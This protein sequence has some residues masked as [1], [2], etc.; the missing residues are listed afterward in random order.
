MSTK[1]EDRELTQSDVG[2]TVLYVASGVVEFGKISSWNDQYVFVKYGE[3]DTAAATKPCDL[4]WERTD[5]D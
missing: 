2:A 4:R 1:I 5:E 3:G